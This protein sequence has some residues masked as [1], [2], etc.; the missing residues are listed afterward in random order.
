MKIPV[1]KTGVPFLVRKGLLTRTDVPRPS[2][3]LRSLNV[4]HR[5]VA[6]ADWKEGLLPNSHVTGT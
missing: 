5:T 3:A 1:V 4:H 6:S 2:M